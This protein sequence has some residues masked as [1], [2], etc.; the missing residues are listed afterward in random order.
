MEVRAGLGFLAAV[1]LAPDVLEADPGA[2]VRWQRTCREE[3]VLVRPVGKGI[4]MSP[5][6]IAGEP[7]LDL[8]ATGL[9]RSLDRLAKVL[10]F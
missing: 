3:G 2:P 5:P 1:E 8:L 10:Q 4:A 6:L 9:P 7:E